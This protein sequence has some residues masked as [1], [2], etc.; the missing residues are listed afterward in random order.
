MTLLPSLLAP[1][2]VQFISV[3]GARSADWQQA[4]ADLQGATLAELTKHYTA[5]LKA[6]GWKQL[7]RSPLNVDMHT[8]IWE[9]ATEGDMAAR[10]L[11]LKLKRSDAQTITGKLAVWLQ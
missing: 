1:A 3:G 9:H 4:G 6:D 7:Y 8:S 11:V 10:Q 2:N 5:Q